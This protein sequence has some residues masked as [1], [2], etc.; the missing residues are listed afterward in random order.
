MS[1]D[2]PL[3][4]ENGRSAR[5]LVLIIGATFWLAVCVAGVYA[6]KTWRSSDREL[7]QGSYSADNERRPLPPKPP[8]RVYDLPEFSLTECRGRTITRS[9]LLGRPAVICFIFTRCTGQCKRIDDQMRRM[10][11][12]TAATD[13][14]LVT[15]TVD[16]AHDTADVLKRHAES[17]NADPKRWWFLTGK[18]DAVYRLIQQGFQLSVQQNTG[19]NRKKGDEVSHSDAVLYVDTAG[20]IVGKY[21][22]SIPDE[23]AKLRRRIQNDFRARQTSAVKG[24]QRGR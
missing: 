2:D 7:P 21:G 1:V 22:G 13:A 10:Q 15:I 14:R 19:D 3:T 17:L 9:D 23:M 24:K 6:W 8:F 4:S 20:R 11:E 18:Q 12:L 16:P 5:R